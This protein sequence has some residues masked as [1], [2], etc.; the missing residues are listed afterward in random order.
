M[1][2]K[3]ESIEKGHGVTSLQLHQLHFSYLKEEKKIPPKDD[4]FTSFLDKVG[5]PLHLATLEFSVFI[6]NE[7]EPF[8]TLFSSRTPI[9]CNFYVWRVKRITNL[10]YGRFICPAIFEANSNTRKMLR[11][12]FKKEENLIS[13]GDLQLGVGTTGAI[14]KCTTTQALE[15]RKF[16]QITRK[17]LIRLFEKLKERPTYFKKYAHY[18]SCLSPNQVVSSKD[19]FFINFFS[20]LFITQWT[21]LDHYVLCRSCWSF[22]QIIY[23]KCWCEKLNE[24]I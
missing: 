20:K 10:V 6:C 4:R 14:K 15:V 3:W 5:F 7:I 22:I 2:R 8:L 16:K 23:S 9:G 12:D 17:S 18:M 1:A 21:R 11:I 13:S 19:E 24:K